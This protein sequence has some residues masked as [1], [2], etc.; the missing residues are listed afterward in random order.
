[1]F[2]TTVNITS[3]NILPTFTAIIPICAGGSLAA[4]STTS[5]NGITGVWTPALNATTTTLYTFTP[6]AGQCALTKNMTITIYPKVTPDFPTTLSICTGGNALS[7]AAT[8][9]NG[10]TGSWLPATIDILANGV[11]LFTPDAGECANSTTLN[12]TITTN[13]ILYE[14]DYICFDA[15]GQLVSPATIDTGLPATQYNFIWT[16]EGNTISNTTA[17]I[18][19]VQAGTYQ[20]IATDLITGCTV[21]KIVAVSASPSATASVY[22][23]QDFADVQE[24]IV[25]VVGGSGNFQYQLNNGPF[26][27]SNVFII[28]QGGDYTVHVRE[29]SGCNTFDLQA[30][31]LNFPKFFTPNN[32]GY[33]D[34]WNVDGLTSTQKGIITLFDRYGKLIKQ[35]SADG[36][37]WDGTYNGKL[38]PSTDYWFVISY[39]TT[40][41]QVKSFRSHFSLKR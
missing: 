28:T 9:P 13:P 2:T 14:S 15:A 19:A 30:T 29:A 25:E 21:T 7:L 39:V 4:L 12:V 23:K 41:G 34:T 20:V 35:I 5:N 1:M 24:I 8:S 33:N 11:Y 31:A 40:L 37:G 22:V 36:K 16:F 18:L 6:I 3:P 17:S 38:M 26:Q 32:D 10:I 27:T